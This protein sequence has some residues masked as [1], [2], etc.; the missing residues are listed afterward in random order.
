[1]PV[2]QFLHDMLHREGV[3]EDGEGGV[4]MRRRM[5]GRRR[6]APIRGG[7]GADRAERAGQTRQV[8]L[9]GGADQPVA[10][11]LAADGAVLRQQGPAPELSSGKLTSPTP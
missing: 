8:G 9:A 6:S 3:A 11:G 4:E 2:L 10:A 1:V 5:P 7:Q